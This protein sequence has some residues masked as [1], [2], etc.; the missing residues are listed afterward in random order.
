MAS[1]GTLRRQGGREGEGNIDVARAEREKGV[2]GES[3]W[4][5]AKPREWDNLSVQCV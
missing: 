3:R 4:S 2:Q 1:R 5:L